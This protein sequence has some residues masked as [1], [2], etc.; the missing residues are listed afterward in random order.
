M[1][2][3]AFIQQAGR[4]LFERLSVV[5]AALGMGSGVWVVKF[6][7]HAP[8]PRQESRWK[9]SFF[10]FFQDLASNDDRMGERVTKEGAIIY[11]KVPKVPKISGAEMQPQ[12]AAP[13]Q[14]VDPNQPGR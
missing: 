6:L 12:T 8:A 14:G 1:D 7:R 10:D 5:S 3:T 13:L 11:L 4:W 9:G 2:N